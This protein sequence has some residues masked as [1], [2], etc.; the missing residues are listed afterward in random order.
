MTTRPLKAP[1][2]L[3]EPHTGLWAWSWHGRQAVTSQPACGFMS[4]EQ[5]LLYVKTVRAR[6]GRNKEGLVLTQGVLGPTLTPGCEVL[7]P[8]DHS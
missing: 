4:P 3:G 6:Q 5:S 2:I 7:S 8:W 1:K